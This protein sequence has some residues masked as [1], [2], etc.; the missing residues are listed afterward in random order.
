MLR[1]LA[2]VSSLRAPRETGL[3]STAGLV[4]VKL[5]IVASGE[6]SMSASEEFWDNI[7]GHLKAKVLVPIVGSELLIVP[8]GDRRVMLS[9][10]IGERVAARYQLKIDWERAT[11]LNDA[12]STCLSA[13]G[14]SD[15]R[16]L[17][18]VVNDV[19]NELNPPVPD[20]LRQLA[21]IADFNIFIS[22][23]FDPLLARAVND[24]R[25]GGKMRTREM[26]FA[27]NQSTDE[28][29]RN[30]QAPLD[31]E[32]VVFQLFGQ[33][34][35]IAQYA[36]HDEDVLEWLHS[37]LTGEARLPEWL[38]QQLRKNPL[39]FIGCQLSDWVSRIVA[40]MASRHRLSY[41]EKD[42]FLVGQAIT[43]D[44]ALVQFLKTFGGSSV[45]L[46]DVDPAEFV[47][48]LCERW[49][50]RTP[51]PDVAGERPPRRPRGSIFISY[52]REDAGAARRLCDAIIKIAGDV[53]WLDE[54]RLHPGDRWE[55]E[56]LT[57]IR[58][59]VCLFLP[60]ISA[61]TEQQEE[62]YVFKEWG[63]A[64][65]RAKGIPRRHFIVPIVIDRDFDGNVERYRQVPEAFRQ[66]TFGR[67]PDGEPETELI[68]TLK[69][70]IRAMRRREAA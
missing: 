69:E 59:D 5:I 57:S 17:Y 13:Q 58:A 61:Q 32:V 30:A 70:E 10:L 31:R 41:Q 29:Q 20:A 21:Q 9:R 64:V 35:S 43:H 63:E 49:S 66:F 52:V 55:D 46:L 47:A 22:T 56:I 38:T 34:T 50:K 53:C 45:H 48:E 11:G 3:A 36:I 18:R 1:W 19:L 44:S 51:R 2:E 68:E 37:L 67:A 54:R 14:R 4:C 28:Q 26:W 65:E 15:A 25:F 8:D 39:L 6:G 24:V 33:A 12:I 27:P 40:R 7:L 23:T 16:Q 42:L 60:L 62:G